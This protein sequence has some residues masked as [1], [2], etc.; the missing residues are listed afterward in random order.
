MQNT[1]NHNILREKNF[2]SGLAKLGWSPFFQDQYENS[3]ADSVPARV[4]GVHRHVFSVMQG[5]EVF[6]VSLA[7]RLYNQATRIYPVVGDW[8][9]V[10]EQVITSIF[11]RNNLLSRKTAGGRSGR[12]AE[13]N[14]EQGIAANLDFAFIVCG[15]DRDYN[16]ARIER[17]LTLTYHCGIEPIILLSKSDLQQ[18]PEQFVCEV[19]AIAPG[20]PVYP[21]S[22]YDTEAVLRV[23]TLLYP[24]RTA[25]LIGS[26]GAGKSTLIN[27]LAGKNIRH[28]QAV[29][30]RVGKGRHTTTSRDLFLLPGGGMVID[31]PGIREIG[32]SRQVAESMSAFPD[33]EALAGQCRF[34]N[35]TH[36]CE[37]GCRV[38]EAIA[39]GEI[40][41][42]RL[43]NYIKLNNELDYTRERQNKSADRVEK[44]R[45]QHISKK[46][47]DLKNR[48]NQQWK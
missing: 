25:A 42:R 24:H 20:V 5:E 33:I 9:L 23:A 29:G 4:V 34:S 1:H 46:V 43:N 30:E 18:N 39:S 41:S 2:S 22:L 32:L 27:Q 14:E 47:K 35:C 26:S 37:P 7:G 19:E 15:L 45:W 12:N 11:T 36:T 6:H 13:V 40:S 44:E 17:Y 21:L 3:A 31:N 10:N 48:R 38:L 8:V 28:T 16:P